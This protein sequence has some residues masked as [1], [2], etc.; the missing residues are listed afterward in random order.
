MNNKVSIE[1]YQ[2]N[3]LYQLNDWC[4]ENGSTSNA[5]VLNFAEIEVLGPSALVE[6]SC[7]NQ[8]GTVH[9]NS[10]ATG[11]LNSLPT[12]AMGLIK[13]YLKEGQN[14]LEIYL[15]EDLENK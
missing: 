13:E 15:V 4:I 1:V 8:Y 3:V 10:C 14:T 7:I 12:E 11:S 2:D 5:L 9:S 6:L